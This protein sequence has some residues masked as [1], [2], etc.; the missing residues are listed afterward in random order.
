MIEDSISWDKINKISVVSRWHSSLDNEKYYVQVEYKEL[1]T[2]SI[3]YN[4]Y[5][6]AMSYAEYLIDLAY[7]RTGF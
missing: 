5:P 2:I 4:N 7:K 1:P 6:D 3:E